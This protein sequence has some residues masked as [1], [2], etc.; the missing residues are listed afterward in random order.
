MVK[1]L[2]MMLLF[3]AMVMGPCLVAL[4]TGVHSESEEA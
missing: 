4:N 2:L 1:D 3:W